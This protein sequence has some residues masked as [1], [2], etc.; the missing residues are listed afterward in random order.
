MR[1]YRQGS[2]SRAKSRAWAR[3]QGRGVP[4]PGTGVTHG[5]RSHNGKRN[6]A[7]GLEGN[8]EWGGKSRKQEA[9]QRGLNNKARR[10][11]VGEQI[12]ELDEEYFGVDFLDD[13]S[14][15]ILEDVLYSMFAPAGVTLNG[16]PIELSD[17]YDWHDDYEYYDRHDD[18]Y[19]GTATGE[20]D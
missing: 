16:S 6:P 5:H 20:D 10:Q 17:E 9:D 14:E 13:I 12:A 18:V 1:S 3:E 7:G 11:A 15:E 2:E 19:A 8:L 4:V